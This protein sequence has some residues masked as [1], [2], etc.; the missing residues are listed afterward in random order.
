[1]KHFK[2]I[3]LMMD[4]LMSNMAQEWYEMR[5]NLPFS[6]LIVPSDTNIVSYCVQQLEYKQRMLPF[7]LTVIIIT[8]DGIVNSFTLLM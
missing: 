1:M 3:L 7:S 5:K 8:V 4:I 2:I 6:L